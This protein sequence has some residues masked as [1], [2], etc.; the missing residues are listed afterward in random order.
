MATN[1]LTTNSTHESITCDGRG[2][3][4]VTRRLAMNMIVSTAV[5][6]AAIPPRAA[7]TSEAEPI[8]K[9]IADHAAS[10]YALHVGLK[11]MYALEAELP[12]ELRKSSINEWEEVIVETDDPRWI[13]SEKN[14]RALFE[15]D[16]DAAMGLI[17]IEPTSL[18]GLLAL[19]R[20]VT[21]YEARGDGW[22]SGLQEDAAKPTAIGKGW[23][24][25]LHRNIAALLEKTAASQAV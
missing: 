12:E 15:A 18:A 24:V 5:A 23:E 13:N 16:E 21:A 9:A 14:V 3:S 10:G 4:T 2:R 6:G 22:P 7:A 25:Y 20:H 17:N 11:T 8:F 19:V 1:E